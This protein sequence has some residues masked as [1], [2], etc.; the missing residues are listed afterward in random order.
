MVKQRRSDASLLVAVVVTAAALSALA[1]GRVYNFKGGVVTAAERGLSKE[2]IVPYNPE[3]GVKIWTYTFMIYLDDGSSGMIQFSFWKLYLFSQRGVIASFIDKGQKRYFSKSLYE[4]ERMTWSDDPPGLVMGP[5]YWRGYYPEFEVHLD[6]PAAEDKVEM[7]AD[8]LF[9]CRTPGWRPGEGPVHYG[10]PDGDWY[11]I[12]VMIPWADLT[13]TITIDGKTREAR[14]YGYC[15][16]NTQNVLPTAQAEKIMA[17]RSFSKE[18]TVNFLEY[19]APE[20]YGHERSTWILVMKGRRI[21]CATDQWKHQPLATD[22]EP[23]HGYNY[24]T[25][26]NIRIDQPGIRLEGELTTSNVVEVLDSLAELPGFVRTM[27]ER[28]FQA[29]VFIRLNAQVEWRLEM[30]GE[31]IKDSWTGKGVFESTTVN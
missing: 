23:V 3:G 12:V 8:L 2:E 31:G 7:K 22:T 6:F 25:K 30:P 29:P 5:N 10:A 26:L 13:G 11:D 15:D 16:H 27:A 17:L 4:N 21:I 1:A 24:P 20:E 9:K 14:G 19:V 18:Y 28:F